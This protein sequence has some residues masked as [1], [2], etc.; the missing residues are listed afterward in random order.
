MEIELIFRNGKDSP[1][2][3][4]VPEETCVKF[5]EIKSDTDAN[6]V[7]EANRR[8]A[9]VYIS[10]SGPAIMYHVPLV[11]LS[12]AVIQLVDTGHML[13]TNNFMDVKV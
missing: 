2:P 12:M 10:W 3:F 4:E 8:L 7:I 1:F 5:A 6:I 13:M 11:A 9:T